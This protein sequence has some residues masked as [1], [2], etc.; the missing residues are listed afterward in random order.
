[1]DLTPRAPWE[2]EARREI[3]RREVP[4]AKIGVVW[5]DLRLAEHDPQPTANINGDF[6]PTPS[7]NGFCQQQE[8]AQMI[9]PRNFQVTALG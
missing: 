8:P 2:K 1:M 4:A 7:R 5:P 6:R 9:F 3:R